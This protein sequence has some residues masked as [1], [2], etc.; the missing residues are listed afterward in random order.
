MAERFPLGV[1]L[2]DGNAALAAATAALTSCS[3]AICTLS[4]T[5][6]SSLGLRTVSVSRLDEAMYFGCQLTAKFDL[7]SPTKLLMK[8]F[9]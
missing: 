3:D 9:V 7:F 8:R 4:V 6:L 1:R 5:T 2:H